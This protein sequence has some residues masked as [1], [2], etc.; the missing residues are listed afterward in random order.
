[1]TIDDHEMR[2][3]PGPRSAIEPM[4]EVSHSDLE[5]GASEHDDLRSLGARAHIRVRPVAAAHGVIVTITGVVADEDAVELRRRLHAELD[6]RPTVAVVNLSGVLTCG[7]IGVKVLSTIRDRAVR[8]GIALHLVHLGAPLAR[9]W[10]NAANL[11]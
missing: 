10:L 6:R 2:V 8:E 11:I 7:V 1:M 5:V 9:R 3:A 4:V